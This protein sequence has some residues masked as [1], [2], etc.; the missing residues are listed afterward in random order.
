MELILEGAAQLIDEK[1]IETMTTNAIAS[2]AG[3]SIGTLYQYFS[4][5]QAIIDVLT[6]RE[7]GSLTAQVIEALRAPAPSQPG[8]K[9]RNVMRAYLA[10]FGN[11]Q[12]I[13]QKLLSY[14]LSHGRS[15][16]LN[17]LIANTTE[18]FASGGVPSYGA[19]S[20]TKADAFVL[21]NAFAG[22]MRGVV[23]YNDHPSLDEIEVSLTK[24]LVN[25]ALGPELTKGPPTH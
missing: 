7:L 5:K 15:Q 11:K 25:F 16:M 3:V 2:R 6:E 19:M 9:I 22:V 20:L 12:G 23:R 8:G 4:D 14:H 21:S 13:R 1:D 18:M 24:L 17:S 10:T